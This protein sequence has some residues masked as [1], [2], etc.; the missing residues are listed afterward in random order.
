[1]FRLWLVA[2]ALFGVLAMAQAQYSNFPPG[3]FN[4]KAGRD[5]SPGGGGSVTLDVNAGT[6]I[7]VR[8]SNA[9]NTS[10]MTVTAGNALV[11]S[12]VRNDVTS[13][14]DMGAGVALTWDNAGTPQSMTIIISHF[15]P[16][17]IYAYAALFGLLSPH[18]G[19]LQLHFAATNA[20]TNSDN[21]VSCV[22]F[23]GVN[24]SFLSAFPNSNTADSATT[25]TCSSG[26]GHQVVGAMEATANGATLLGTQIYNDAANGANINAASDFISG[27]TPTVGANVGSTVLVCADVSP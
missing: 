6:D 22:S 5:P 2:A 1:M 9:F 11:C 7:Y 4:N 13:M 25:V 8:G 24:G 19:N 3:V 15:Q 10:I 27:A 14:F 18:T 12:V 16:G 17:T 20:G 26:S 23:S 21:F